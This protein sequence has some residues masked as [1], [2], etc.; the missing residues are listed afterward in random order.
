MSMHAAVT[1]GTGRVTLAAGKLRCRP[2]KQWA[3]SQSSA[4][5]AR[6]K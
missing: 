3:F 1:A 2:L 6:W 4:P 5:G